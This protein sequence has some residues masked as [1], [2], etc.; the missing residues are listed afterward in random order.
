MYADVTLQMYAA[1][2]AHKFKLI[3]HTKCSTD[4]LNR[5]LEP[6]TLKHDEQKRVIMPIVA[7]SRARPFLE[8]LTEH[9]QTNKHRFLHSALS[10][11]KDVVLRKQHLREAAASVEY[12]SGNAGMGALGYTRSSYMAVRNVL[13]A[14]VASQS[15]AGLAAFAWSIKTAV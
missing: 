15:V 7:G 9:R 2:H 3:G 14:K 1:P 11:C 4:E 13:I 10:R 12:E 6:Y 8:L 5:C